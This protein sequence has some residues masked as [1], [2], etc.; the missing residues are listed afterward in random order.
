M[1]A[2]PP[3][4]ALSRAAAG[5]PR[6]RALLAVV[7]FAL[8]LRTFVVAS[9]QI[10]SGSMEPTLA[11]GDRVVVARTLYA[12]TGRA[13]LDRFLPVRA[14][15]RGDVVWA[16]SP[17]DPAERL[18]KRCA[19]TAGQSVAGSTVPPGRIAVVGDLRAASL[20][21]RTFGP[22]PLGAVRGRVVFVLFSTRRGE[23]SWRARL[24]RRVR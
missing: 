7:P 8:F 14:P 18:V 16:D 2:N 19:A 3:P 22:I 15:R 20:D 10:P 12:R 6:A 5:R 17:L 4:A 13:A 23:A 1:G 21:S 9:I 11:P 24:P